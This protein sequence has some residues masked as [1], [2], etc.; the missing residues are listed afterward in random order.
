MLHKK[1]ASE[2]FT[3]LFSICL[4]EPLFHIR[5]APTHILSFTKKERKHKFLIV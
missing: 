5:Y 3:K 1:E 4:L 2:I